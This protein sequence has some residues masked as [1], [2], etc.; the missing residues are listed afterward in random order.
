MQD[1]LHKIKSLILGDTL[2]SLDTKTHVTYA[3]V[4]QR[5]YVH[6][7]AHIHTRR[8]KEGRRGKTEGERGRENDRESRRKEMKIVNLGKVPMGVLCANFVTLS[9]KSFQNKQLNNIHTVPRPY[10]KM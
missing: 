10:L 1:M 3:Q 5:T 2:K 7:H 6:T 4:V 9:L 8:G